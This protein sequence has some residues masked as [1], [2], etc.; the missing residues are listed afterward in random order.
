MAFR[1]AR[2]MQAKRLNQMVY[3]HYLAA[4]PESRREAWF[5]SEMELRLIPILPKL[6][7]KMNPVRLPDWP[8][9]RLAG[10]TGATEGHGVLRD[11]ALSK[12]K[13]TH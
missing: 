2:V 9:G 11:A 10:E 7:G 6:T 12:H 1:T 13:T 5:G 8:I 3:P 4:E